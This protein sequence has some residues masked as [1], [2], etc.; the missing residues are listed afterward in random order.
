MKFCKYFVYLYLKQYTFFFISEL[1]FIFLKT[2]EPKIYSEST[3]T[4]RIFF[5]SLSFLQNKK[6]YFILINKKR[7]FIFIV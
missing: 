1:L 6:N 3:A 5:K 4:T 2:I 7:S